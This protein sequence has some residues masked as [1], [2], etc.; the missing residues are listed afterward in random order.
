[1]LVLRFGVWSDTWGA[2]SNEGS[3]GLV[4]YKCVENWEQFDYYTA[5]MGLGNPQEDQDRPCI[6]RDFGRGSI[7]CVC[8]STYCDFASVKLLSP[9]DNATAATEIYG[10][11]QFMGLPV[12]VWTS[13]KVISIP[14]LPKINNVLP[15][16]LISI[17]WIF[18]RR[19]P[20]FINPLS[21]STKSSLTNQLFT[22]RNTFSVPP[23]ASLFIIEGRALHEITDSHFFRDLQK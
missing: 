8:N 22:I 16:F 5:V 11:S 21:T 17:L 7:V 12:Q 9:H 6:P 23:T 19:V 10:Q 3:M 15:C 14:I 20:A 2:W 4:G 13:S 18:C 1:M